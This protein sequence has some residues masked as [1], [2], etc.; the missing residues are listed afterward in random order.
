MLFIQIKEL[1]IFGIMCVYVV[2]ALYLDSVIIYGLIEY[3]A[4]SF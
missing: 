2:Y 3:K 1:I 4:R